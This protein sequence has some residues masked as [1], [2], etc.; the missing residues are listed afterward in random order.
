MWVAQQPGQALFLNLFSVSESCSP[1]WTV[2]SGLSGREFPKFCRDLVYQ[3]RG[4]SMGDL[5]PL[6][7]EEKGRS[8]EVLCQE[9]TERKETAI[10]DVN[11]INWCRKLVP[12]N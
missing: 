3:G 10:G 1:N 8:E 2:L 12:N 4:L 9:K 6:R 11:L 7:G 5:Y